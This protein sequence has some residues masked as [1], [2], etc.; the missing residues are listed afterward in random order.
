MPRLLFILA[1]LLLAPLLVPR[2]VLHAL[3]LDSTDPM[4]ETDLSTLRAPGRHVMSIRIDDRDRK[5]IFVTL[6]HPRAGENLPLLFFFHGAGGTAQ[7][8]MRTYGWAEKAEKE[9]FFAVF[10]EGLPARPDGIGSFLLNPHLWRDQGP[11]IPVRGVDDVHFFE[12]LLDQIEAIL[13]VDTRRIYVTGFSNGA[14]MTFSLGS[15][16]SD[17]IA[18]IAPV[19]SQSF[20]PVDALA[21]A[22]PI[23]YLTGT[24]DPLIPY[25]GGTTKPPWGQTRTVA[26]VQESVDAWARRDG[27]PPEPQMVGDTNG[28]R[29]LR[30]GPGRN[31]SEIFFTTIEG[32][33]HHWPDTVEPLPRAISGPTLDPFNATDRIWDFFVQHPLR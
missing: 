6:S 30:Y 22:L 7:Q 8:A 4:P 19:S 32:N 24:A 15:H 16:F 14:G 25:D 9:H 31:L 5:F 17:R 21:R 26:P 12:E 2:L 11:G 18:A 23:Y 10:P 1:C 28:V 3:A 20:V 27:C 13:P 29:V 33:G